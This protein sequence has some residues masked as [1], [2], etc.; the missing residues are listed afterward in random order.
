MTVGDVMVITGAEEAKAAVGKHLVPAAR[1]VFHS[2]QVAVQLVGDGDEAVIEAVED[3]VVE[4]QPIV[5]PGELQHAVLG[6]DI[7]YLA[8]L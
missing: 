4:R 2:Q 7:R 6:D 1:Q 8:A 5:A 3:A